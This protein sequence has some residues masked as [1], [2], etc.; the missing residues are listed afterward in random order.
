MPALVLILTPSKVLAPS[1]IEFYT[2]AS[3]TISHEQII[4]VWFASFVANYAFS[5]LVA[6]LNLLCNGLYSHFSFL[7][8]FI[9]FYINYTNS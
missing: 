7:L 5:S 3:V 2:S 1:V 9:V 6:T 8:A 4:L